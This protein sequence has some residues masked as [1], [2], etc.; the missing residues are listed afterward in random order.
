MFWIIPAI[1]AYFFWALENVG[2]KYVFA[3]K[4]VN[5]YVFAVWFALAMLISVGIIPFIDFEIPPLPMLVFMIGAGAVYFLASVPYYKAL[6]IEEV[7]RVNIWFSLIP[8]FSFFIGWIGLGDMLSLA[9]FLA[10]TFLVLGTGIAGFHYTSGRII[11]SRAFFLLV[12]STFLYALQA[13]MVRYA[14]FQFPY[15]AVYVWFIIGN[16]AAAIVLFLS[17]RFRMIYRQET[18][19]IFHD[20]KWIIFFLAFLSQL[21]GFCIQWALSLKQAALVY[22]LEGV[23]ILFVFSMTFLIARK[24]PMLLKESL[25]KKDMMLKLIALVCVVVGIV[26]LSF[27]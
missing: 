10:F 5:P 1:C 16:A 18:Q 17:S 7:T 23:Q 9:E 20:V 13:V 27:A 12:L 3:N 14:S 11:F 4:S 22:A 26:L 24:Y 19:R 2:N 15:P 21:A 8:V 6:E 25:D